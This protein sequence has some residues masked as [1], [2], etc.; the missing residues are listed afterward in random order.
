PKIYPDYCHSLSPTISKWVPLRVQ[1]IHS[2]STHGMTGTE[3]MYYK[4]H[5]IKWIR[6]TGVIVAVDDFSSRR[7][8][9]V[10][11]SSG[12]C[13]ECACPAPPPIP[14]V[15]LNY[16]TGAPQL[17]TPPTTMP[18][19]AYPPSTEKPSVADGLDVGMVVK[20]KG[21]PNVFRDMKQIAIIKAEIILGTEV[22]VRCWNEVMSWR[23]GILSSP[24]EVSAEQEERFRR[25]AE[26]PKK[27]ETG[28]QRKKRK[29]AE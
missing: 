20:I 19:P 28:K 29:Y 8:Y 4:N 9:T 22:E 21:K 27:M 17:T 10:D 7:I 25:K 5:P 6:I 3:L 18:Q 2:L 11:D 13:I 24:W 23:T 26:R 14:L 16:L 1:D 12:A 15:P